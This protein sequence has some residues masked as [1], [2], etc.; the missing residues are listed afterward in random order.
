MFKA[1]IMVCTTIVSAIV[2]RI[3]YVVEEIIGL[4]A[5]GSQLHTLVHEKTRHAE[6][7]CWKQIMNLVIERDKLSEGETP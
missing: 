5:N 1:L 4:I 2:V 6:E 3:D 7:R